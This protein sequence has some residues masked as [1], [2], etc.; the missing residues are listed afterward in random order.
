MCIVKIQQQRFC[1]SHK[2]AYLF[3]LYHLYKIY[4][5]NCNCY[6]NLNN[7][8]VNNSNLKKIIPVVSKVY[9]LG[10]IDGAKIFSLK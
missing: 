3:S 5:K 6:T 4:T 7:D 2:L 9:I 10:L 1:N 8:I